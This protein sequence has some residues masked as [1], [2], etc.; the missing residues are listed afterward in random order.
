MSAALR[1]AMGA[2]KDV[3]EKVV[4][5][6]PNQNEAWPPWAP[7]NQAKSPVMFGLPGPSVPQGGGGAAPSNLRLFRCDPQVCSK[8]CGGLISKRGGGSNWFCISTNCAFAHNKKVF[9]Q[10]VDGNYY[11]MEGGGQGSGLG[12]QTRALLEPMLPQAAAEHSSDNKEVL[13]EENSMEGWLSVFRYLIKAEARG[14]MNSPT[15]AAGLTEFA[16][17]AH[18]L[19]FATPL[20]DNTKCTRDGDA[21]KDDIMAQTTLDLQDAL[22]GVQ[23]ELG[24]KSANAP[25]GTVHGGLKILSEEIIKLE[26]EVLTRLPAPGQVDFLR[27]E[28]KQATAHSKEV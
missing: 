25:Y 13:E 27:F 3:D 8:I 20:Q 10:L 2:L 11:I 12:S 26:V 23:G 4:F 7:E 21:D 18:N 1:L 24:V 28:A 6:T 14:N 16:A 22:M 19:A 15:N 17:R 5:S 9:D